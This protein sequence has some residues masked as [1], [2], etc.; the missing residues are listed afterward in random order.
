[1]VINKLKGNRKKSR[2]HTVRIKKSIDFP[3]AHHLQIM[4][5][6]KDKF[7]VSSIAKKLK[8]AVSTV[9]EHIKNLI[10]YEFIEPEIV[11]NIKTFKLTKK[12]DDAISRF[13]TLSEK[14]FPEIINRSHNIKLK[15]EI[16]RFPKSW[17]D[18]WK[19]KPI[20]NWVEYS[21]W[22]DCVRVVRT[23]RSIL[24][25]LP[26]IYYKS[27]DEA[28]L[29]SGRIVDNVIKSLEK[30]YPGL[31]IGNPK[32]VS[33]IS[34]Q[35]HS[36]INDPF[37]I[38]MADNKLT[39]KDDRIKIDHSNGIPEKEFIHKKYASEDWN[40]EVKRL[41][42]T[43]RNDPPLNTELAKNQKFL[44]DIVTNL[45][46]LERTNKEQVTQA[47]TVLTNT[48]EQFSE[49]YKLHRQV[50]LDIKETLKEFVIFIKKMGVSKNV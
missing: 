13:L 26:I 41:N 48:A 27:S 21:K 4:W 49:E 31:K 6:V 7:N 43:I 16:R 28:L 47:T 32:K 20:K 1:M 18:G 39:Y 8:K 9:S 44:Y 14:G 42:D 45:A 15:S 37:S 11:S 38:F 46:E 33:N 5:L 50:L 35:S 3:K 25:Q 29:E 34:S 2:N 24:F 36:I 22:F 10:F 40:N 12:G 23:T 17:G 30:E 19:P